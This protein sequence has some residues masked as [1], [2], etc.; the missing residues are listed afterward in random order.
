MLAGGV[1][2]SAQCTATQNVNALSAAL[3]SDLANNKSVYVTPAAKGPKL[4][5]PSEI[6][7]VY[8]NGALYV[9]SPI[10]GPRARSI[11]SGWTEASITVGQP[12]GPS[13]A[14]SGTILQ[15]ADVSPSVFTDFQKKYP[16]RWAQIG[17]LFRAGLSSGRLVF[18]KYTPKD[19]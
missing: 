13:F 1:V 12:D 19:G 8:Q 3:K 7:F 6:W 2:L 9:P 5:G 15:P 11:Q 4:K 18:I 17:G 14:A 10:G 16:D